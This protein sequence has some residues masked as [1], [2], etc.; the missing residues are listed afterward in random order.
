MGDPTECPMCEDGMVWD[1]GRCDRCHA[2]VGVDPGEE[3]G[4][5]TEVRVCPPELMGQIKVLPDEKRPY[6]LS[7]QP[8]PK[9][10]KFFLDGKIRSEMV[11]PIPAGGF[12]P[13]DR[14]DKVS[15][16][17]DCAATHGLM[18]VM[19]YDSRGKDA[20]THF[21]MMRIAV[22]N[23]RQEHLRLPEVAMGLVLAGIVERSYPGD[24]E[25]HHKWLDK[26]VLPLVPEG[27]RRHA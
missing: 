1:D 8:C 3:G 23:D 18:R 17:K 27:P 24:L 2:L 4:D 22:G 20:N 10:L 5:R 13:L 25:R 21:L 19:N 14:I 26:Y 9:C 15:T 6:K 11:Q 12:A 7:T 16:C